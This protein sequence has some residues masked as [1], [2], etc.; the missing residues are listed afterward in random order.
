M[1]PRRASFATEV[2]HMLVSPTK[3]GQNSTEGLDDAR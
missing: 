1:R 3:P 2:A